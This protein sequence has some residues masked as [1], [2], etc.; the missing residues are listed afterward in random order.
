MVTADVVGLYSS[1]P[2]QTILEAH[3]ETLD[4]REPNKVPKVK[5]GKME[6]FMLKNNYFK[7]SDKAYPHTLGTAIGNKFAP[8]YAYRFRDQMESSYN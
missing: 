2:Y 3:R 8:H 5:P 4:N 6:E 7:F 1:I